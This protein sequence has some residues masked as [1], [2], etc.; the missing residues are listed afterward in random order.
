[1]NKNNKKAVIMK[2]I[3][4]YITQSTN[5]PINQISAYLHSLITFSFQQTVQLILQDDYKMNLYPRLAQKERVRNV[6]FF[7]LFFIHVHA[8]HR[9]YTV[10]IHIYTYRYIQEN[11]FIKINLFFFNCFHGYYRYH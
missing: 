3:K 2:L 1:M 7:V 9:L 8:R 6:V 10:H 5:K 4:L 11:T